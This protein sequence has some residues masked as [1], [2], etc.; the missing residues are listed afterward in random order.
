[1]DESAATLVGGKIISLSVR[2]ISA[3]TSGHFPVFG[4]LVRGRVLEF[5]QW[6][7]FGNVADRETERLDDG[8]AHRGQPRGVQGFPKISSP[9]GATLPPRPSHLQSWR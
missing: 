4:E 8:W 2:R 5:R 6:W 1:M 7:S 9:V 3:W